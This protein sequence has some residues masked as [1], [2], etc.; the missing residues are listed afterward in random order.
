MAYDFLRFTHMVNVFEAGIVKVLKEIFIVIIYMKYCFGCD[1]QF[2]AKDGIASSRTS[3]Y[4]RFQRDA[5]VL[6][7]DL[8]VIRAFYESHGESYS[9]PLCLDC[10]LFRVLGYTDRYDEKRNR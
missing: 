9:S 6:P 4:Q 2:G 7:S 8:R 3:S 10:A 5:E 1:G